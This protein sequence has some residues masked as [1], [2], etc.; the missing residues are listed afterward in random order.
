MLLAK[1][2]GKVSIYDVSTGQRLRSWSGGSSRE[3]SNVV[4]YCRSVITP[5]LV[6][7]GEGSMIG[8]Y[9]VRARDPAILQISGHSSNICAL[10]WSVN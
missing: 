1:K 2:T 6:A 7:V 9:D 4:S 10:Q 3:C 8:L 5:Y